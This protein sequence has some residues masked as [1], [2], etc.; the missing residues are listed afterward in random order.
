MNVVEVRSLKIPEVKVIRYGRHKDTRGF[1]SEHFRRS[2]L[3]LSPQTPFLKEVEFVQ[4]NESYSKAGTIRGLHFQWD[5]P[6]GKLVKTS[7]G[8]MVDLALDIRKGSPTYGKV[9]AHDMP[10]SF[11]SKFNE[12]IWVPPGF[13]H[14]NF[15]PADTLIEYFCSG[16]YNPDCEASISPL[17]SDL[18]WSWCDSSLQAEFEKIACQTALITEKDKHGL[19]LKAWTQDQRS[20]QF[21]Y[22]K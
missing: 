19:T 6:L 8:R 20:N 7:M 12:W 2:D 4:C 16:E 13:A 21:I 10:S 22:S 3:Q 17:A 5:P 9:I 1:F 14:G 11:E 15:F 18:D